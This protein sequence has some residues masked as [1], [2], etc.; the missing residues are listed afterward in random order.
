MNLI[1]D[2]YISFVNL[3][4]RKD[5]LG[6]MEKTLK[7]VGIQAIR[8]PGILP[9]EYKG[10]WRRVETMRR[11]TPGAIGCYFSQ[12][13]II[14]E[15]LRQEKHAFVMEDDLIFCD[16][17][18]K[19]LLIMEQWASNNDWDI[20]WMGATFHVNPPYWHKLDIGRDAELT[21][22]PRIMKTYGAFSTHAYLINRDSIEKIL[23]M[24]DVELDKTIGIDYSFIQMQPYLC[25]FSF[26]PGCI[27][28][29]DNQSN[30][31]RGHT[32]FSNFR[33]L[34][35]TVENSAYWFQPRMEDFNPTTFDWHECETYED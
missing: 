32:I 16:D 2:S 33:K 20:F 34:N 24:L 30:I 5:R 13:K 7:K 8:T 29:Y 9:L 1:K 35:G 26:V 19:R 28:Q 27:I 18:Q 22:D 6:R 10:D 15:A 4:Q 12:L 3:D 21:S 11:R 17:F 25:T 14:K 31:G 23:A